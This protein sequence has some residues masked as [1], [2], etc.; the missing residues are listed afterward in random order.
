MNHLD[1]VEAL[2]ALDALYVGFTVTFH[3]GPVLRR[4]EELF[5]AFPAY[6]LALASFFVSHVT[7]SR[8]GIVLKI[9]IEF[10]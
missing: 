9:N 2:V 10:I 5:V 1:V 3:M 7:V 6:L 8:V 4:K